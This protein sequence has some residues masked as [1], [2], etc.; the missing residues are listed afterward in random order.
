MLE[1]DGHRPI[2]DSDLQVQKV[3]SVDSDRPITSEHPQPSD[4]LRDYID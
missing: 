2:D 1:V 4:M 3:W